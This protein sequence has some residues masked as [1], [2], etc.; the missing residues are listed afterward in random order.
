MAWNDIRRLLLTKNEEGLGQQKVN[1][2]I[3]LFDCWVVPVGE[4]VLVFNYISFSE[5]EKLLQT[6]KKYSE[7]VLLYKGKGLHRNA[8]ELLAKYEVNFFCYCYFCF[9]DLG[10]NLW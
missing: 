1:D 9:V 5:C 4:L 3:D 8:L 10:S 2:R 6:H 7:L